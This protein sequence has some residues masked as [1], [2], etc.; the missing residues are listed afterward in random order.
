[1]YR[2]LTLCSI[3]YLCL[4]FTPNI[5][6]PFAQPTVH[7]TRKQILSQTHTPFIHPSPNDMHVCGYISNWLCV[8]VR[9]LVK[10]VRLYVRILV[11][12]SYHGYIW[13]SVRRVWNLEL[14]TSDFTSSDYTPHTFLAKYL[15]IASTDLCY[16]DYFVC[17]EV[18][19]RVRFKWYSLLMEVCYIFVRQWLTLLVCICIKLV[20]NLCPLINI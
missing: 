16:T 3:I 1:M 20:Y 14:L 19:S 9:S 11:D 17:V 6:L 7:N 5:E 18:R 4:C 13:T 8:F 15:E 2:M 12:N 10:L